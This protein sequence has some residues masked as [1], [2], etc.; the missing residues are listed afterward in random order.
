MAAAFLS[1]QDRIVLVILGV[2]RQLALFVFLLFFFKK[3]LLFFV[4][5]FLNRLFIF[6]IS[7]HCNIFFYKKNSRK[8]QFKWA[9]VMF[10]LQF[11]TKKF[12]TFSMN[13][14]FNYLFNLHT[15]NRYKKNILKN[16]NPNGELVLLVLGWYAFIFLIFVV[17]FSFSNVRIPS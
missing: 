2:I 12:F 8:Q 13:I 6:H 15:S 4:K 7:N 16:S 10:R 17:T 9:K 5:I 14:F 11:S 1:K 3:I